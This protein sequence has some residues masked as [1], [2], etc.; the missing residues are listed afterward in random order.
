MSGIILRDFVCT[1]RC[2][3][4]AGR[5]RST[6]THATGSSDAGSSDQQIVLVLVLVLSHLVNRLLQRKGGN[7]PV[8]D[9]PT[10]TKIV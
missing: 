9:R 2:S 6:T 7:L 1:P 4:G 3:D 8:V 5:V 10:L